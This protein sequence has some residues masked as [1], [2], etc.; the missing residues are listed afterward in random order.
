MKAAV[1]THQFIWN[2]DPPDY[3]DRRY[4]TCERVDEHSVHDVPER[5]PDEIETE[6]RILGEKLNGVTE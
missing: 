6:A 2:G 4:C 5:S 1:R 3:K